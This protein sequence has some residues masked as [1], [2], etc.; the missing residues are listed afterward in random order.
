M[1]LMFSHAFSRPMRQ[2]RQRPHAESGQTATRCPTL[3]AGR[4]TRA[5]VRNDRRELV[6]LDPRVQLIRVL[7]QPDVAVEVVE[8]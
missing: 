4:A 2:Q 6:P 8:V 7:G 3:E 1:R 5:D